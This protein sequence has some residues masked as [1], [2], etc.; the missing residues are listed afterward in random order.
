MAA[1][2]WKKLKETKQELSAV[3]SDTSYMSHC[4]SDPEY[5]NILEEKAM[6]IVKKS[7]FNKIFK[8]S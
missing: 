8:E 3:S 1:G 4:E 2:A 5:D 7:K 6:N